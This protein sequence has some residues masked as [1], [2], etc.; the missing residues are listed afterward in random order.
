MTEATRLYLFWDTGYGASPPVGWTQDTDYNLKYIRGVSSNATIGT[1]GNNQHSHTLTSVTCGT[2][3]GVGNTTS[4]TA[5]AAANNHTHGTSGFDS[6][7]VD[8]TLPSY[9]TFMIIYQSPSSFTTVPNNAIVF[10]NNDSVPASGYTSYT[11]ANSLYIRGSGQSAT[12]STTTHTHSLNKTL[13]KNTSF[14]LRSSSPLNTAALS[15]HTHVVTGN[16]TSG[17]WTPSYFKII[18]HRATSDVDLPDNLIAG[19]NGEVPANWTSVSESGSNPFH[20]LLYASTVIG[21]G[22]GAHS[23]TFAISSQTPS[24]APTLRNGTGVSVA[25]AASKHSVTGTLTSADDFPAYRDMVF[26]YYTTP[27][28]GGECTS[29]GDIA[30]S[31]SVAYGLERFIFVSGNSIGDVRIKNICS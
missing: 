6:S 28:T 21:T 13:D 26:G 29:I 15:G 22:G 27:A 12:V 17:T 19:F 11:T 9:R 14:T 25:G 2:N 5:N 24:S 30:V 23:H 8:T 20:R 18:F 1:G 7:D 16:S 10:F 4:T 3:Y 31:S